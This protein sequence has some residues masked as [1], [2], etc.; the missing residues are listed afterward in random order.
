M[1]GNPF[2]DLARSRDKVIRSYF[3]I[4]AL[5][6]WFGPDWSGS[7]SDSSGLGRI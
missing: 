6:S 5:F 2:A 7:A 3:Y 4:P 1:R